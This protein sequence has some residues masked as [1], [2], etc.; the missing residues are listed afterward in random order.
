MLY[1]QKHEDAYLASYSAQS[2]LIQGLR[3]PS[4]CLSWWSCSL[5]V[6]ASNKHNYKVLYVK[7]SLGFLHFLHFPRASS[8]YVLVHPAT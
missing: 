1:K 7:P 6:S 5:V 8:S 3:V 2:V 4:S